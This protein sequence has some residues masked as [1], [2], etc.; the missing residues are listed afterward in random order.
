M[1]PIANVLMLVCCMQARP[2][3]THAA[4]AADLA[5]HVCI[6]GGAENDP[7]FALLFDDIRA[8]GYRATKTTGCT[9][10]EDKDASPARAF[11]T[12]NAARTDAVVRV[13]DTNGRSVLRTLSMTEA[14]AAEGS[15]LSLR[16]S[17]L[18]RAAVIE[19]DTAPPQKAIRKA[20]VPTVADDAEAPSPADRPSQEETR[21]TNEAK[22]LPEKQPPPRR[23]PVSLE[24][25]GMVSALSYKFPAAAQI[26]LGAHMPFGKA[27][28]WEAFALA[29]LSALHIEEPE[30]EVAVRTASLC[31][32]IRLTFPEKDVRIKGAASVG[33]GLDAVIVHATT[34]P[35]LEG[36]TNTAFGA[37]F[38]GRLE[39][40]I[41]LSQRVA[42]AAGLLVATRVPYVRITVVE[43]DVAA[44]SA[45][46]LSG[47]AGIHV[48][49]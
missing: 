21:E 17:E 18:L 24:A 16:I 14:D 35:G 46:M 30:G 41:A 29:P 7:L 37:L 11:V 4:D 23:R 48:R 2:V 45:L 47:T 9:A 19:L 40:Q 10:T 39:M 38:Y 5:V 25:A 43:R 22:E 49:F 3:R 27:S 28:G 36:G 6:E 15:E 13:R 31:T 12:V 44:I 34:D 42:L 20:E 33:L 32:G 8:L 1:R 26:L